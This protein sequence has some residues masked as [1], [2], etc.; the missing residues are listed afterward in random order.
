[1]GV[2][3]RGAD[4]EA[5]DGDGAVSGDGLVFGTYLHGLFSNTP[6]VDALLSFLYTRRGLQYTASQSSND[7]YEDLA[8]LFLRHVRTE[9]LFRYFT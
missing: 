5:F 3:E 8:A 4:R 1:M 7:P 9:A 6:A 2:T